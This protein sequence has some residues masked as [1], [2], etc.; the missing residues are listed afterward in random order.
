MKENIRGYYMVVKREYKKQNYAID[1]KINYFSLALLVALLMACFIPLI[2][3]IIYTGVVI[4]IGIIPICIETFSVFKVMYNQGKT[5]AAIF[6][7]LFFSIKAISKTKNI[8][9]VK[10]TI[11]DKIVLATILAQFIVLF[12]DLFT[13]NLSIKTSLIVLLI[14]VTDFLCYFLEFI[15]SNLFLT[16]AQLLILCKIPLGITMFIAYMKRI[17]RILAETQEKLK[18]TN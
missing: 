4:A 9:S 11:K 3:N 17:N 1:V 8:N 13:N 7:K 12:H 5:I 2:N 10:F 6:L 14:V 16:I 18:N 15:I